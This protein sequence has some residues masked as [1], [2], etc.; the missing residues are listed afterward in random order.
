MSDDGTGFEPFI[1]G[2]G[3][4]RDDALV[5]YTHV[6]LFPG[7]EV[8]VNMTVI[9]DGERCRLAELG[10]GEHVTPW[11]DIAKRG[12]QVVMARFAVLA[13]WPN[14]KGLMVQVRTK[15]LWVGWEMFTQVPNATVEVPW[16]PPA[17]LGSA[18]ATS[19][20]P[21]QFP[22][23]VGLEFACRLVKDSSLNIPA[24]LWGGKD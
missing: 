7:R 3:M 20:V 1:V 18:L 21:F 9:I 22:V 15:A 4:W 5:A 10:V 13:A 11:A 24:P 17:D 2:L 23:E 8:P 19:P 14:P 16:G 12:S 6:T